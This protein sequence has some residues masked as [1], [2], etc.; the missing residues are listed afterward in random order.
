MEKYIPGPCPHCKNL[1]PVLFKRGYTTTANPQCTNC[2]RKFL[3]HYSWPGGHEIPDI[4]E[5]KK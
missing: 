4:Y 3:V 5:I 2:G 1:T